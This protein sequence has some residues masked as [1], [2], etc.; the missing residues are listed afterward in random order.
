MLL[1]KIPSPLKHQSR[2]IACFP[3]KTGFALGSIEGRVA[4]QYVE[5]K[6]ASKNFAFK[7]H[8]QD[9]EIYAVNSIAFHPQFGTFA[10]A[11]ADGTFNF[12]DKD[13][14]QRLK[15]FQR[16]SQP[17]SCSAWSGDGHIYAYG[18]SYDWSKGA[19]HH[20]LQ[21]AKN[22]VLLH[23]TPEMEIKTRGATGTRR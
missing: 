7:C 5:D 9:T 14:R 23:Y 16:C 11:G 2:C 12:W 13:S 4:I 22:L 15:Q 8:R 6:D 1:Q 19:E 18:V 21:T 20:N 17:L 3:D 10:T